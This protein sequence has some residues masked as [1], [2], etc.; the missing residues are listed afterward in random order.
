MVFVEKHA[1]FTLNEYFKQN[2]VPKDKS[3]IAIIGPEGGFSDK[4]FTFFKEKNIP[5][6]SLGNLI[7]RADTAVIAALSNIIYG[8]DHA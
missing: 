4:E 1:D 7:Y 3:I 5:Q 6:I 8:M 2:N